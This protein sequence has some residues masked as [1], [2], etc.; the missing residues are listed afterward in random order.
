MADAPRTFPNIDAVQMPQRCGVLRCLLIAVMLRLDDRGDTPGI[1]EAVNAVIRHFIQLG[2]TPNR[3]RLARHHRY[4]AP[5]LC[6]GLL[7]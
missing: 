3:S 4:D 6:V 5:V 2:S 7:V 1:V